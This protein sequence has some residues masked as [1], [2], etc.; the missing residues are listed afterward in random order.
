MLAC[1]DTGERSWDAPGRLRAEHCRERRQP[2]PHR[3]RLVIDDVVDAWCRLLYRDRTSSGR[4]VD[5]QKR[6]PAIGIADQR[7][8]PTPKLIDKP[9]VEQPGIGAIER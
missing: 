7:H 4:V 6:P 8:A 3:G 1:N 5:V 9:P 2:L